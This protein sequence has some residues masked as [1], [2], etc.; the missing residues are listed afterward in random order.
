MECTAGQAAPDLAA[1]REQLQP[2]PSC[3]YNSADLSLSPRPALACSA[4][5]CE[6]SANFQGESNIFGKVAP[7]SLRTPPDWDGTGE[8]CDNLSQ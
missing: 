6:Y 1:A 4:L 8:K 3:G 2:G 7:L 5:H